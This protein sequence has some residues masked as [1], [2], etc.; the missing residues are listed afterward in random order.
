MSDVTYGPSALATPANFVTVFRLLV[1]PFLFAMIVSEGTGWGLFALWVVLA[2]TDG[3]DGWIARRYGTT[4]SGAFLDPLADKV[5]ILGAMCSLAV[6]GRFS[7]VPVVLIGIRELGIS[8]YRVYW[9]RRGLAVPARG[10]AKA[11]TLVQAFAVGA[12]LIPWGNDL[13]WV[14]DVSLWVSVV[15][16]LVSGAQYLIDGAR[17]ATTMDRTPDPGHALS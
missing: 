6:I 10:S 3:I 13:P 11:K 16:A 12:A 15:L 1:S 5:L 8:L 9:G 17:A 7:W 14:A 2:G 4:R